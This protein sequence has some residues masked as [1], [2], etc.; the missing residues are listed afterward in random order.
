MLHQKIV[1]GMHTMKPSR[2]KI[3]MRLMEPRRDGVKLKMKFLGRETKAVSKSIQKMAQ[4]HET[5]F[6]V[7]KDRSSRVGSRSGVKVKS[8]GI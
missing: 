4:S 8:Q 3:E 5:F 2:C 6:K 1:Y 7:K